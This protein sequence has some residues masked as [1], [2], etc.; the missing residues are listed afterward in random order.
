[1]SDRSKKSELEE[2]DAEWSAFIKRIGG[3]ESLSFHLTRQSGNRWKLFNVTQKDRD[4]DTLRHLIHAG[5]GVS[6]S[7][8]PKVPQFLRGDVWY[9][10]SGAHEMREASDKSFSELAHQA[11]DADLKHMVDLDLPRTF[12]NNQLFSHTDKETPYTG[13]LRNILYALSHY[14]SDIKYCQGFNYIAGLLLLVQH[15]EEKAFWTL[16]A[17]LEHLFPRDYFNEKL[18]GARID[19]RVMEMLVDKQIPLLQKRLR[20]GGFELAVFTLPWFICLFINTLPFITVMRIWDVILFEGDKALIR[21]ALALLSIGEK[22]LLQCH[23]F[24]EFSTTFK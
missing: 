14:R 2:R 16:A 5:V 4:R 23:D 17:I 6:L 20:E 9:Y 11:V 10:L 22:D 12:A 7:L 18:T 1:M 24:S 13:M 15:D 8:H 19:Q 3:V 21:I